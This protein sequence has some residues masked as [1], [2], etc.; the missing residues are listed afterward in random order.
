MVRITT[1]DEPRTLLNELLALERSVAPREGPRWASRALDLDLIAV[2]DA[3]IDEPGLRLPHPRMSFRPFV[4]GPAAELAPDWE[5]PEIGATLAELQRTLASPDTRLV[6]HGQGRHADESSALAEAFARETQRSVEVGRADAR[7]HGTPPGLT[8]DAAEASA[9]CRGP[10]LRVA[11]C[12][13]GR[14]A[15]EIHAAIE[16]VW[17]R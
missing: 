13:P 3:V 9:A 15:E 1:D 10:R 4:V 16:C 2:G 11:D 5:H 14:L 8:I 12:D 6:V 7:L 17:P